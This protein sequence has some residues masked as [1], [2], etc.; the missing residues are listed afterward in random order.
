MTPIR[1][2]Q[3][4]AARPNKRRFKLRKRKERKGKNQESREKRYPRGRPKGDPLLYTDPWKVYVSGF[5][6]WPATKKE[7]VGFNQWRCQQ[8]P[9]GYLFLGRW[10]GGTTKPDATRGLLPRAL[11]RI[12][13]TA[14]GRPIDWTFDTLPVR[15]GIA[16][17]I[18]AADYDVVVNLGYGVYRSQTRILLERGAFNGRSGQPGAGG[19]VPGEAGGPATKI[20]ATNAADIFAGPTAISD[21]VNATAGDILVG[22]TTYTARAT[23]A[24]GTNDYICNETHYIMLSQANPTRRLRQAYFVHIP[25]PT[26]VAGYRPLTQALN[27]IIERLIQP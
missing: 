16:R 10:Y 7:A 22:T 6:D 14:D 11:R 8:N 13:N 27:S 9:S 5:H 4:W 24:R 20:D 2:T 17:S 23:A 26:R 25:K 18:T 1:A 12:R 21:R 15:W 3:S 19:L